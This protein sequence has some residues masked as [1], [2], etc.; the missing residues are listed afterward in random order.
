MTV[1]DA[2]CNGDLLTLDI[3]SVVAGLTC[4]GHRDEGK[5][6][7]AAMKSTFVFLPEKKTF[8]TEETC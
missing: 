8:I 5:S 6:F 7:V 3:T 4:E 2:F 1:C